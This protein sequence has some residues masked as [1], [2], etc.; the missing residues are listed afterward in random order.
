MLEKFRHMGT[1]FCAHDL[2]FRSAPVQA[3]RSDPQAGWRYPSLDIWS[4]F[5]DRCRGFRGR[6]ARIKEEAE[7]DHPDHGRTPQDIKTA[8]KCTDHP[9]PEAYG[10][11]LPEHR[12]DRGRKSKDKG[13]TLRPGL[14]F[15]Q[16][17]QPV[18]PGGFPWRYRG[19]GFLSGDD[20]QVHE[21]EQPGVRAVH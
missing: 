4:A 21:P 9:N 17:C 14:R 1:V 15:L 10:Q 18:Y 8:G 13:R 5:G 6:G 3:H 7:Q 19:D 12:G 20:R 2:L 11:S 16:A